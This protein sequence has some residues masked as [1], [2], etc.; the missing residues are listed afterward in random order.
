MCVFW[1]FLRLI[2]CRSSACGIY[3]LVV[4][5]IF[6]VFVILGVEDTLLSEIEEFVV[7]REFMFN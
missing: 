6:V 7:F 5:S 3:F 2:F 4:S 1:G